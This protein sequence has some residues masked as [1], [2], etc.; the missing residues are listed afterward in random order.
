LVHGILNVQ[1]NR[2][3]WDGWWYFHFTKKAIS[4]VFLKE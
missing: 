4:F 1:R 2:S 3:F